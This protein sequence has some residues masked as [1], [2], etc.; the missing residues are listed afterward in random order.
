MIPGKKIKEPKYPSR[1]GSHASMVIVDFG[2]DV[3]LKDN[4][5]HYLT[6]KSKMDTGLVDQHRAALPEYREKKLVE[7]CDNLGKS[8]DELLQEVEA[9]ADAETE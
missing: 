1:Y 3:M 6:T 7:Y 9:E 5:G 8:L 4:N 2:N